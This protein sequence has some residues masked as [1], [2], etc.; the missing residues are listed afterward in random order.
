MIKGSCTIIDDQIED[1][2]CFNNWPDCFVAV[3]RIG[4]KVRS[5]EGNELIVKSI[6]HKGDF[7]TSLIKYPSINVLIG[8]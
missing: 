8:L 7:S 2:F 4:D 3:P 5:K 1:K 6:V